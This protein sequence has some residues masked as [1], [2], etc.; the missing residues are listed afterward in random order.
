LIARTAFPFDPDLGTG[1]VSMKNLFEDVKSAKRNQQTQSVLLGYLRNRG[2][3]DAAH[4]HHHRRQ[5]RRRA[6][7][8]HAGARLRQPLRDAARLARSGLQQ[9]ALEVATSR[10]CVAALIYVYDH[11]ACDLPKRLTRD[12]HHRHD[13]VQATL[14][15]HLDHENCMEVTV[16]KGR[17]AE[18]QDFANHIIAERGVRHGHVVY[19]PADGLHDHGPGQ[20]H[21]NGRHSHG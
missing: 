11:A 17:G 1:G 19:L 15:M 12:F 18:V 9:A 13:L 21:R 8:L 16:L 20:T 5:A 4:D 3:S 14:H 6:R 7:S 2:D 10:R